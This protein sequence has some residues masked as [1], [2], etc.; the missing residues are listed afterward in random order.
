MI[1]TQMLSIFDPIVSW[2]RS[3]GSTTRGIIILVALVIA[4]FCI[5]K[6]ISVAKDHDTKPI[7]WLVLGI[8]I[9]CFGIA[10]FVGF[11]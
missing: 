6:C 7:K 5:A 4:F 1:V 10:V 3:L 8:G 9:I 2:L 11:V